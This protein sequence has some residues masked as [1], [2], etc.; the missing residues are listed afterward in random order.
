M[1]GLCCAQAPL[2]ALPQ[3]EASVDL[4]A[5]GRCILSGMAGRPLGSGGMLCGSWALTAHTLP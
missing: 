1:R 2:F 5:L 4:A 3:R